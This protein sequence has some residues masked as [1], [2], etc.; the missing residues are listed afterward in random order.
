MSNYKFPVYK[1][2]NIV[3][4]HNILSLTNAKSAGILSLAYKSLWLK[5][6]KWDVD[7]SIF[8]S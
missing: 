2:Q 6:D 1:F 8:V 3:Y 5:Q 4:V 7:K